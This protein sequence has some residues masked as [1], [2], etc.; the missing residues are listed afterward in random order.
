MIAVLHLSDRTNQ[1]ERLEALMGYEDEAHAKHCAELLLAGR[2]NLVA[3]VLTQDMDKAF[4]HTNSIDR[5]WYEPELAL[6]RQII[7]GGAEGYRSTS[8]GD[9]LYS[10]E[11]KEFYVV[12]SFGFTALGPYLVNSAGEPTAFSNRG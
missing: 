8:V 9:I 12:A 2:Y 10:A 1:A 11:D 3:L 4:E 5:G 6:S 7:L